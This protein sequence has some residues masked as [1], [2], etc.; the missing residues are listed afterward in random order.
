MYDISQ[1][2]M[3]KIN[4]IA[5]NC[6]NIS[7]SIGFYGKFIQLNIFN[8]SRINYAFDQFKIQMILFKLKYENFQ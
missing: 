4:I 1:L 7:A 6:D 8:L 2:N 3:L 5:N